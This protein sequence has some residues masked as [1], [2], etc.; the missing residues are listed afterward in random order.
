MLELNGDIWKAAEDGGHYLEKMHTMR[1][2]T[3]LI[4]LRLE[5]NS[6]GL[7]FTRISSFKVLKE[8][9]HGLKKSKKAAYDQ[10]VEAGIYDHYTSNAPSV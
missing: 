4:G 9:F 8:Y 5:A 7:K 3:A 10:L 2:V 1:M 6:K